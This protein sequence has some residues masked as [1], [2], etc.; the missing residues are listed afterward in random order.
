MRCILSIVAAVIVSTPAI[1][2]W[3]EYPQP[4]LGFI[5]EF[6]ADPTISTGR[7]R[8]VLVQSATAHI[9]S[10]K[11]NQALYVT[12]VVDLP[13]S[14]EEGASLLG[15]AEFNLGLL[16]DV[17]MSSASR[18][19]P[20]VAAIFGHMITINC[21]SGKT[22]DLLGQTDA[23]HAWFKNITGVECPDRGRLTVNMFFHRGRLY[24]MN[25]INLPGADGTS[26]GPWALRFAN[27]ISFYAADGSR[28]AADGVR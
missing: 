25:G 21:R 22:T 13:D 12:T 10:V 19:E 23:A 14:K 8:T 27:A 9:F 2:A 17:T 26:L 24:L 11:E 7:Y 3:K 18:V 5:V 1:A 20:G 16:G 4:K 15:E 28:N 6:P